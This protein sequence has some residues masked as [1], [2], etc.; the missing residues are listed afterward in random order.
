MDTVLI[1]DTVFISAADALKVS[2]QITLIDYLQ[3]GIPVITVILMIFALI[4][5]ARSSRESQRSADAAQRSAD[6]AEKTW[7]SNLEYQRLSCKP[8]LDF[9]IHCN[10]NFPLG[11]ELANKGIGPAKIIKIR[12]VVEGKEF[13]GVDDSYMGEVISFIRTIK[14]YNFNTVTLT[15]NSYFGINERRFIITQSESAILHKGDKENIIQLLKKIK[16]EIKYE[17]L[18]G[19]KDTART[20][21]E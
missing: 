9:T 3:I 21:N 6:A 20:H 17:S 7:K 16:I 12:I 10:P 1:I 4:H 2:N 8:F 14:P 15:P 5:S 19:D 11:I 13:S 18:F